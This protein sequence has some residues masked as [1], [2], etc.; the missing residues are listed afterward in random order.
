MLESQ[1]NRVHTHRFDFC[2]ECLGSFITDNL[3]RTEKDEE[4]PLGFTVSEPGLESCGSIH[5]ADESGMRGGY[6]SLTPARESRRE[7]LYTK[8]AEPPNAHL[9]G[10]SESSTE[11]SPQCSN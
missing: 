5:E 7:A 2:A 9:A 1:L 8:R 10:K 3:G 11:V 6:S 4:L